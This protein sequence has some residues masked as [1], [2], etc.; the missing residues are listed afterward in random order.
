MMKRKLQV[1]DFVKDGY[2]NRSRHVPDRHGFIIEELVPQRALNKVFKV[3]W[4]DGEIC[5]RI[6]DYDLELVK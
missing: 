5:H 3:L 4:T 2:P 6:Y 1:G